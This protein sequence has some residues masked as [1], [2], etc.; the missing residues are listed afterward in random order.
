ML[1]GFF[2]SSLSHSEGQNTVDEVFTISLL[3]TFIR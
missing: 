1:W 2:D 3:L